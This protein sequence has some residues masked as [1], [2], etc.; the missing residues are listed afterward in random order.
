MIRLF[1][2]CLKIHISLIL[3]TENMIFTFY[4]NTLLSVQY[5]NA[6]KFNTEGFLYNTRFCFLIGKGR[7]WFS[8]WAPC[9]IIRYFVF[10]AMCLENPIA[11]SVLWQRVQTTRCADC[12]W[13][14]LARSKS[15]MFR[16][17]VESMKHLLTGQPHPACNGLWFSYTLRAITDDRHGRLFLGECSCTSVEERDE[18]FI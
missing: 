8:W 17:I 4:L 15:R 14:R 3:W 10:V 2:R 1:N 6:Y 16:W 5:R 12:T 13:I 7:T 9:S 11:C 18:Y